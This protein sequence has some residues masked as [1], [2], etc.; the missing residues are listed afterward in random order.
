VPT[1]EPVTEDPLPE[2]ITALRAYTD[3]WRSRARQEA[4]NATLPIPLDS[5]EGWII[6]RLDAQPPARAIDIV[7]ATGIGKAGISKALRRLADQQL[8]RQEP[9]PDD[10]RAALVHLTQQGQ[11]VA[12]AMRDAATAMV[13]ASVDGWTTEEQCTLTALLTR[14]V[15]A[16]GAS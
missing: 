2:L 16:Q 7:K 3:L 9:D 11:D 15:S 8:V 13:R 10:S 5:T 1:P 14:L 12:A 6:W 4:F